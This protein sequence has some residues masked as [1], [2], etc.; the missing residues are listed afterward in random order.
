MYA[1]KTMLNQNCPKQLSLF[2]WENKGKQKSF[3][4]KGAGE[5]QYYNSCALYG[6]LRFIPHK[7]GPGRKVIVNKGV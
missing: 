6:N 1:S 2:L 4:E 3:Q 7:A 5:M